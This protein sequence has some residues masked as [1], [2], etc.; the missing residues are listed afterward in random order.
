MFLFDGIISGLVATGLF[1]FF[2]IS[3]F[4][5]YNIKKSKWNLIGRYV[6]G[7]KEKKYIVN[8]IE[9]EDFIDKEIYIGYATHYLIGIIFGIIY[10]TINIILFNN[11]SWGLAL[12]IGFITVLGG[13]CVTMPFI[14]NIGF[15]ACKKEEQKQIMIQNLL[16]HFIFGVGLYFGYSLIF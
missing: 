5:G 10:V 13:W 2:Q 16:A 4:Y 1:D 3:L 11:P 12:F 9:S 15:F 7:L 14:F 8:D 6:F